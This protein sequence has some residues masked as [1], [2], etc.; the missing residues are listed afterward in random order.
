MTRFAV[1]GELDQ[2]ARAGFG[3]G[4]GW[5][6][7]RVS[8][9]RSIRARA[10][11]DGDPAGRIHLKDGAELRLSTSRPRIL[12]RVTTSLLEGAELAA[13]PHRRAVRRPA[14]VTCHHDGITSIA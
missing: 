9:R 14:L 2:L 5:C 3:L 12:G 11:C 8:P 10:A 7:A 1:R 13:A 4:Q 6:L